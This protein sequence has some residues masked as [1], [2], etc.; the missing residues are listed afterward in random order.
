M[1]APERLVREH[2]E[3]AA[4]V[5]KQ[6]A[7]EVRSPQHQLRRHKPTSAENKLAP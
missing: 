4:H 7:N 1:P 3:A 6:P 5:P 2:F